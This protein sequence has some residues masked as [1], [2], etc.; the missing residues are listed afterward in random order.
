MEI[1]MREKEI[2]SNLGLVYKAI[3]QM[4]FQQ[5]NDEEEWDE[6]Y[7]AGIIGLIRAVDT[8][9]DSISKRSTYYYQCILNEIRKIY[10]LRTAQKR[11]KRTYSLDNYISTTDIAFE[12]TIP[13][14]QN[15]EEDFIVNEQIRTMLETLERY[16][17]KKH[18]AMLKDNF[19]IGCER[20]TSRE[21]AEK[22]HMSKQNVFE[23]KKRVLNWLKRELGDII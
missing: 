23:A 5:R 4:N 22:Y 13:S 8:Y 2:L 1:N 16:K 11:N 20:L 3:Q 14:E 6:I 9:N 7:N 17:N 10:T 12:D 21:I 15:I 18:L 19:G